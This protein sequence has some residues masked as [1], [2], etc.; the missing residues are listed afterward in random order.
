MQAR[1][2]P[3]KFRV[4]GIDEEVILKP[5]DH[6]GTINNKER[7]C[8]CHAFTEGF[9]GGAGFQI[10]IGECRR[11]QDLIADTVRDGNYDVVLLRGQVA[12]SMNRVSRASPSS[13]VL[14]CKS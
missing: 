5:R 6:T 2:Y 7:F 12:A 4:L 14:T 3:G 8:C 13:N 10:P 11:V 9:A 1:R